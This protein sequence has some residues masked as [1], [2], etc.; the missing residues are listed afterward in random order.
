MKLSQ[1]STLIALV[2]LFC[3]NLCS[4][5]HAQQVTVTTPGTMYPDPSPMPIG[6]TPEFFTSS[7]TL[8][9]SGQYGEL[10]SGN[11]SYSWSAKI[12]KWQSGSGYT[13]CN[14]PTDFQSPDNPPRDTSVLNPTIL[15]TQFASSGYYQITLT[16]RITFDL[17]NQDG[18]TAQSGLSA[19]GSATCQTEVAVPDFSMSGGTSL[20]IPL[21][22]S[23]PV[24]VTASPINNF[25]GTIQLGLTASNPNSGQYANPKGVTLSSDNSTIVLFNSPIGAMNGPSSTTT[26]I[27]VSGTATLGNNMPLIVYGDGSDNGPP[28]EHST[29][30]NLTIP[31]RY[32]EI[33]CP[34]YDPNNVGKM[35]P[36][37]RTSSTDGSISVD[38]AATWF[39]DPQR[40]ATGWY[41]RGSMSTQN[42]RGFTSTKTYSW[43][44]TLGGH[45]ADTSGT[46]YGGVN[47]NTFVLDDNLSASSQAN[48]ALS[49]SDIVKLAIANFPGTTP[50]PVSYTIN[51][52]YPSEN[53]IAISADPVQTNMDSTTAAYEIINDIKTSTMATGEPAQFPNPT[54]KFSIGLDDGGALSIWLAGTGAIWPAFAESAGLGTGP[55]GWGVAA[56]LTTA[57]AAA[58]TVTP[59]PSTPNI[60]NGDYIQYCKD[61]DLMRHYPFGYPANYLHVLTKSNKVGF[62]DLW[63]QSVYVQKQYPG[64]Y[65]L[66]DIYFHPTAPGAT[67]TFTGES[68]VTSRVDHYTGDG[69]G[70]Q[71]YTGQVKK[72]LTVYQGST[73]CFQW[74]YTG[75]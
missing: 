70:S 10:I 42:E 31:S 39:K 33:V 29:V 13:S 74:T 60:H 22:S 44:P 47:G 27:N 17:L 53:W 75:P 32:A 51:W 6:A 8:N 69:Y 43:V 14:A 30:F 48:S 25:A 7:A 3:V 65:G 23:A 54:K 49:E 63:L 66:H 1:L 4:T 21:D 20:T 19:T 50:Y 72:D 24:T 57:G 73:P 64:D 11:L 40:T 2:T 55:I 58:A 28:V 61:I 52:H 67:M 56:V 5:V 26:T 68:S 36:N 71:G 16:A 35:K 41:G 46:T 59:T 15:R 12:T 18:S 34:P 45:N 37:T 62:N 9:T 38:A